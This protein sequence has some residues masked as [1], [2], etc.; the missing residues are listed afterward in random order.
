MTIRPSILRTT[1]LASSF[2]GMWAE[3]AVSWAVKAVEWRIV[4]YL[5]LFPSR[6]SLSFWIGM[7]PPSTLAF[8]L[9]S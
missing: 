4:T 6:N 2:P 3:A 7:T 1:V 5:T 9:S 8:P